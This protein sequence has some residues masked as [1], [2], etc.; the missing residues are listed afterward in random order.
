M[1]EM[2]TAKAGQPDGDNNHDPKD[3]VDAE[4]QALAEVT[5]M[6]SV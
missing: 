1:Q 5:T 3:D 2:Q 4:L 6:V